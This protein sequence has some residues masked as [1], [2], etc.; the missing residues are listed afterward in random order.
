MVSNGNID[1]NIPKIPNIFH[2][3]ILQY[4]IPNIFHI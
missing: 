1:Y 3:K 4:N 2:Y